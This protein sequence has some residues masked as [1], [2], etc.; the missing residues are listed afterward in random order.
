MK[1]HNNAVNMCMLLL[2]PVCNKTDVSQHASSITM[3]T[4]VV[5]TVVERKNYHMFSGFHVGYSS[6]LVL[7]VVTPCSLV[8]F[9]A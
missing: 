5:S 1:Y 9:E 3:P 2:T 6:D 4:E 8:T 7:W